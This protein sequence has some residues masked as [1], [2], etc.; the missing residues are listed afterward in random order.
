[1]ESFGSSITYWTAI[2]LLGGAAIGALGVGLLRRRWALPQDARRC[3]VASYLGG[4]IVG[5]L[6][7]LLLGVL[8]PLILGGNG[9]WALFAAL[10]GMAIGALVVPMLPLPGSGAPWQ[11]V[12]Y[13]GVAM[14]LGGLLLGGCALTLRVVGL[15]APTA[16]PAPQAVKAT[17][18][19]IPLTATHTP[20]PP[21]PTLTVSPTPTAKATPSATPTP[22][23]TA[24]VTPTLQYV[25][26]R[27]GECEVRATFSRG[28]GDCDCPEGFEDTLM[29]TV[30]EDRT[31]IQ[32]D[33]PS[34]GDRNTGTLNPVD[35]SFE[36]GSADGRERYWG[37]LSDICTGEGWNE[38]EDING[39][40]CLWRV[41][42]EPVSSD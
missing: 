10:I 7:A 36:I 18:T 8:A 24:T 37:Y 31:A 39:C 17:H 29:I 21:T 28:E 41:K 32:F 38:Y 3:R 13:A 22:T 23:P 15:G 42:W 33:Q 5:G 19:P 11:V 1:M 4:M 34:T 30:S 27:G 20:E 6:L 2:A 26:E 16:G 12:G 14:L 25:I 35:G 40:K 9:T